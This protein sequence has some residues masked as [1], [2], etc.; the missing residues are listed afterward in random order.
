MQH[1]CLPISPQN[2]IRNL[3]REKLQFLVPLETDTTGQAQY[4]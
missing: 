1:T 2:Q 4:G 3:T